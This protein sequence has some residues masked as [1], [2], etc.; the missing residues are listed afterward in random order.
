MVGESSANSANGTLVQVAGI[1]ANVLAG[2]YENKT[3]NI[4]RGWMK[5]TTG[6]NDIERFFKDAD[7]LDVPLC[8]QCESSVHHASIFGN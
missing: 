6:E 4:D 2:A 7:S 8:C 3:L 1:M 5:A